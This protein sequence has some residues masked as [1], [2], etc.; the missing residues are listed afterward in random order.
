MP[1]PEPPSPAPGERLLA[2]G[3]DADILDWGP[4]LVLRRSRTGRPLVREA[5]VMEHVRRA[6][7]PVPAVREVR[8][9][10]RELVMDRVD[11]PSMLQALVRRPWRQRELA[12]LLADL[13]LRLGAITAPAGLRSLGP[14][15][16]VLHQ[17][18][19]P[20]NVL[21]TGAGPVVI[22]WANAG[23]GPPALDV[24]ST[25]VILDS[26]EAPGPAVVQRLL[27]SRRSAFVEAFLAATG[28]RPEA[29]ALL[30][31]VVER[32]LADRNLTPGERDY[33]ARWLTSI[34]G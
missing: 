14:G 32:R 1:G 30:G 25:W 11:G 17:D 7:Y 9:E 23:C 18:L 3:R 29:R 34:T 4:G 33:L 8:A 26:S 31:V 13:H 20:L 5:E 10:G 28:Q 6:G 21:M 16:A 12:R 27:R 15:T 19:H 24:A 22:D 2:R